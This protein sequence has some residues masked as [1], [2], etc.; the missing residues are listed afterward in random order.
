[1]NLDYKEKY[2]KYKNKYLLAKAQQGGVLTPEQNQIMELFLKQG[3]QDLINLMTIIGSNKTELTE[4]KIKLLIVWNTT[5]SPSQLP[6]G[7]QFE[8]KYDKEI[9]LITDRIN[10]EEDEKE[11]DFLYEQKK[12]LNKSKEAEIERMKKILYNKLL[13]TIFNDAITIEQFIQLANQPIE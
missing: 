4:E 6:L 11:S 5:P 8:T 12:E 9:K 2:L 3:K 13:S 10:S 7:F 1:M